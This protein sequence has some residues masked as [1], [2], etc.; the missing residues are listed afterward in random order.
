MKRKGSDNVEDLGVLDILLAGAVGGTILWVVN[1]PTDVLKTSIQS[2]SPNPSERV[3][4]SYADIVRSV[5]K[6]KGVRGFYVGYAPAVVRS[7][8]ANAVCFLGYEYTRRVLD[9]F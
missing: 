1:Y 2:D 9:K 5:Y 3:F 4:K 8:P 6:A 7:A